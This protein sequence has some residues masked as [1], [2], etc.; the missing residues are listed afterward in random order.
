MKGRTIC[1]KC[2][3]EFILELDEDGKE[4]SVSCPKCN[5]EF[6][7]K[8]EC[9]VTD[10]DGECSWEE[11]GEPRKTILSKIKPKTNKPMVAA[12]VLIIVF[13]I[14]LNTALFSDVFIESS[15]EIA[16]G[17]G[18]TGTVK[19]SVTDVDNNSIGEANIKIDGITAKTDANGNFTLIEFDLGVKTL[20]I[21]YANKKTYK[22]EILVT[23][24]INYE[25]NIKLNEG[26]GDEDLIEFNS[27]SCTLIILIFSIFSLLGAIVCIKRQHFDVAIVGSLIGIFSFGFFFIGTILSIIAFVIIMKSK[28]EFE[29]GKKGKTF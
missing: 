16:S 14:G 17:I 18:L 10:S 6:T 4:H 11:H 23:P 28:E 9:K 21:S 22:R 26:A 25:D 15:L 5:N 1:P 2:K 8:A 29:D 12:I 3:H 19:I 13:G 7:I 20:E 27:S 24:F